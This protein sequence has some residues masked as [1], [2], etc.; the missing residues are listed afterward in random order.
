MP[1]V[2]EVTRQQEPVDR[3][4]AAGGEQAHPARRQL[5]GQQGEGQE[6]RRLHHQQ[7]EEVAL[8]GHFDRAQVLRL[9]VGRTLRRVGHA[10]VVQHAEDDRQDPRQGD[11]VAPAFLAPEQERE[12]GQRHRRRGRAEVA[13]ATVHALGA[14]E[15]VGREPLPDHPDAHHETRADEAEQEPRDRRLD[16]R[17]RQ[18]EREAR[19]AAHDQQEGI[20]V[21]RS[22]PVG[23][24]ADE[25]ARRDRERHVQ[26]EEGGDLGP[27]EPERALDRRHEGRVVEPHHESDEERHPAHVQHFHLAPEGKQ[28][29]SLHLVGH[30]ISLSAVLPWTGASAEPGNL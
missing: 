28:V 10:E 18:R 15:F 30:T 14:A 16:E 1:C 24:H 27:G 26:R 7:Q 11:G 20:D 12:R 3:V 6:D 21:P 17:V 8:A 23:E 19:H 9:E 29:E 4:R 5:P 22:E 25:N 13:P 2:V